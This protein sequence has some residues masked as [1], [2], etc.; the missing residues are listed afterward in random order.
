[1][2]F[3]N[4]KEPDEIEKQVQAVAEPLLVSQG[5]ELVQVECAVH[6]RQKFVRVYMD[7]P[8]GVML[9]DCVAVSRELGDLID[10]HIETIGPYR[11]EVSSPGPNR[12]VKTKADFIRFEGERV[13]VET[14]EAIDGR[15]KFT[16]VLEKT[17][18]DSVTIAV[19]GKSFDIAGTNIAR[20]ILAG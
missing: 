2:A 19:D 5:L 20:A 1:M 17:N 13:R 12:P 6:N 7:K 10:V 18:E 14:H 3:I 15:K 11:L 16:G 8:G 9:D 4:G